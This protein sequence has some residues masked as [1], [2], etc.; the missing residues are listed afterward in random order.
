V[1]ATPIVKCEIGIR[2]RRVCGGEVCILSNRLLKVSERVFKVPAAHLVEIES[3]FQIC[4]VRDRINLLLQ[5]RNGV[6]L[7]GSQGNSYLTGDL[8]CYFFLQ[9][10]DIAQISLV[11]IRPNMVVRTSIDKLCGDSNV[12]G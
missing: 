7:T 9:V 2:Q 12:V 6:L 11:A 5:P 3:P 8:F 10:E 1:P 4:F